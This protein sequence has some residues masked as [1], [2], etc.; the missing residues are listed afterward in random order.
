MIEKIRG[1]GQK[2]NQQ[3]NRIINDIAHSRKIYMYLPTWST[4]SAMDFS[5]LNCFVCN[6]LKSGAVEF[7]LLQPKSDIL[8]FVPEVSILARPDKGVAALRKG[9]PG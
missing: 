2:N 9:A 7:A 3:C 1:G 5:A 6:R 4:H 8:R